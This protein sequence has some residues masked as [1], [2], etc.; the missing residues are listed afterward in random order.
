MQKD[1]IIVGGGLAGLVSAI[2]L[3]D[4]GW[5]VLLIEKK[6]YPFH[7]VCGEYIS[8]EVLPLLEN[9]GVNPFDHGAV[10][11]DRFCLSSP[12]GYFAETPLPLGGFGI[13]RYTLDHALC[14]RARSAGAEIWEN[15]IVHEI[16]EEGGNHTVLT[17]QHS[18]VTSGMVIG[19]F[20]KRSNLDRVMD[21]SFF[22]QKSPYVGIKA[23]YEWDM[24]EDLV[25]LHTFEG[26]YCGV[27][28]VEEGRVNVCYMV[29]REIFKRA[30]G[31][32]GMPGNVLSRNPF[33]KRV[34]TNAKPLFQPPIAIN[35]ISFSPK[36]LIE[37]HVVMA[38]DAAG[39]ITPLCGNGMAMAIRSAWMASDS[40]HRF[41]AG[42][43]SRNEME[44][45]YQK[46]WK[47]EFQ[48]RLWLGRNIQKVFG[49]PWLTN[50]AVKILRYSPSFLK[51]I[52]RLTH[53]K[54]FGYD[55][56]PSQRTP[57]QA[58]FSPEN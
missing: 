13:S 4:Q 52:V 12:D 29:D 48:G 28:K 22:R 37:D 27:S 26:G 50:Q 41:L 6:S 47:N 20:G 43:I 55:K 30:G 35:E 16:N 49:N 3:S 33:L 11:I 40:V 21:R 38:G 14:L 34:F 44:A 31:V 36:T 7:R 9:I 57:Y 56:L 2:L 18:P 24:S 15:T 39:M 1:V 46:T 45:D 8:N 25:E 10:A 58:S 53:G 17:N 5:E 23:H 51:Q 19:T 54:P 42:E 32:A